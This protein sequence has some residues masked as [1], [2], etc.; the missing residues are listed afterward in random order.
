MIWA[1]VKLI[2]SQLLLREILLLQEFAA[3]ILESIVRPFNIIMLYSILNHALLL[4][5]LLMHRICAMILDSI[6]E[7]LDLPSR[8]DL[9]L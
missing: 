8:N 3:P 4:Q 5:C 1:N 7:A 6:L 9:G 2:F